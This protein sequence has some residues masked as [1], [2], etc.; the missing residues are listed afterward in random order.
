M[1]ALESCPKHNMV[2]YLEKT[3]GNAPFHKIVDFLS[4]SSIFYALTKSP[5]VS[6]SLI[7]QFWNSTVSQTVN[8]LSQIKAIVSGKAVSISKAS[9]RRDLLFNDVDGIG[10][11][12]NFEIYENLQLIGNLDAKK[13]FLMYSRFVQVFLNNQLSNLPAP[14]DNFPIPVLTKKVFTN[15]ARK[16]AKFSRN[17]TP[18]FPTMLTLA[19]VDEGEGGHTSNKAEGRLNLEEL[20]VLCTNLSNRVLALETI[21]DDQ[22]AEIIALRT[23]IKKLEKKC[24]PSISHH[25][26]WLRSVSIKKKLRKKEHVSKQERKKAKPGLIL[27]D[28]AHDIEYMDTE[29]AVDEGRLSKE[30]EEQKLTTN[31]KEID[32]KNGSGEKG[33]STEEL[34]STAVPETISIARPDVNAAR[35][36]VS[37]AEPRIPSTTTGIFDDEDITMAQTLIKMKEEKAKENEKAAQEE[38]SKDAIAEMY[39]EV[40]A[41][42][43]AD[44]LFAAKLQQKEREEYTIEEKAKFLAETIAAQRKF[45]N[46]G[47]YKHSKLKS[48]TFEEIQGM[49]ERQK[50]RIDDFKP[51]DLDGAVKDGKKAASE[52]TSKKEE[53]LEEPDSTK[54]EVKQEGHTEGTKKRPGRRLKMKATKKSKRQKADSDLEEEKQLKDF[55]KIVP[56]EE[57]EVD[58][59]VPDKRYLIVYWK[60]EFYHTDRYGVPH[61]YYKV[62]RSDG[63]SRF[64]IATPEE[65]QE[66]WIL[67]RW[68]FYDNCGVHISML[69]DGTEFY[70]LAER[71]YPLTKETLKRMLALRLIAEFESKAAFDL[72]RF[73]QKK[74][75]E[76]GSH[77]GKKKDL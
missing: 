21:K 41:G 68:N 12:T 4:R 48:K 60:F 29:D 16:S 45:R 8:N 55:L 63:S 69:E 62:F 9:I 56:D 20:F 42:I 75:D 33:G 11:L 44:A 77:D 1:D 71:R 38:A 72:L 47:G 57:V 22:A 76:S 5:K 24:K 18:L 23:R 30:T 32:E 19:E 61:D 54:V 25:R 51:M 17:I 36:E 2:A 15:M 64:E 26:A 34:V 10:C 37:A 58:Y 59:E 14:L 13:K 50:R 53:V 3:E 66:E 46:M 43:D 27:D 65:N 70:M 74:I 49:Y 28:S 67:K 7:E 52:D 35:Q 31:T 40:Q 73:I 6:T 39:D